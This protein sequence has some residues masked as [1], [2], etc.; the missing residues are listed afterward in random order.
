MFLW[1]EA[2]IVP[3]SVQFLVTVFGSH[4]NTSYTYSSKNKA[5][6]V[7]CHCYQKSHTEGEGS[8]ASLNWDNK[9]HQTSHV[10]CQVDPYTYFMYNSFQKLLKHWLEQAQ[11]DFSLSMTC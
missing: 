3:I 11:D 10:Q 1:Y 4:Q 5:W 9:N 6:L 8:P 7:A 2:S